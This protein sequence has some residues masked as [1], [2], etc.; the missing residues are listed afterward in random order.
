LPKLRLRGQWKD[1]TVLTAACAAFDAIETDEHGSEPDINFPDWT[2]AFTPEDAERYMP[3]IERFA[4]VAYGWLWYEGALKVDEL[5]ALTTSVL[6]PG[7]WYSLER[8]RDIL[9]ADP[10]FSIVRGNVVTIEGVDHPLKVLKEKGA[11]GLPLRDFTAQELVAAA[12][13]PLPLTPREGEIERELNRRTGDKRIHLR[14]LQ[15]VIRNADNASGLLSIILNLCEPRDLDEANY[16]N[17]L[18]TE[19]WDDTFRYELRGRTPKEV[20]GY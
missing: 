2:L 7:Q 18:L 19:M 10:M 15:R 6:Q 16:F 9:K 11:R 20:H 14:S 1:E 8:A 5:I 3:D 4:R 12:S 17:S 13:G